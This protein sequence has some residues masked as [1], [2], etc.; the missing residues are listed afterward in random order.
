M[1]RLSPALLLACLLP[2][3]AGAQQVTVEKLG[4]KKGVHLVASGAKLS[5]VLSELS[6]ALKFELHFE[7]SDDR[8]VDMDTTR[9]APELVAKLMESDSVITD[10]APDPKCPGQVRLTRVWV[11]PKGEDAPAPHEMTPMEMYR[12]AHGLPPEDAKPAEKPP[13]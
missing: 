2:A 7:G 10:D 5:S 13:Q 3:V 1:T 11:L 8:A 12:K 4:C 9:R 6:K